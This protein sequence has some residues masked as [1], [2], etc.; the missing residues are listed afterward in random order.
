MSRENI[1]Y[2]SVALNVEVNVENQP[3]KATKTV[4]IPMISPFMPSLEGQE[5]PQ[6]RHDTEGKRIED[7]LMFKVLYCSRIMLIDK[8]YLW[9]LIIFP[10]RFGWNP[11][12]IHVGFKSRTSMISKHVVSQA[13]EF[14]FCIK[15]EEDWP[16]LESHCKTPRCFQH[17]V[18]NFD[19]ENDI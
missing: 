9:S 16:W 7:K 3:T 4:L 18:K 8:R 6:K 15:L 5:I 12:S 11:V 17:E 13:S 14:T 1:Y 2:V 10:S 19:T